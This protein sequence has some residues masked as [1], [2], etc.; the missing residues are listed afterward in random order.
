MTQFEK[1]DTEA[2]YAKFR[3]KRIDLMLSIAGDYS[4]RDYVDAIRTFKR[5]G[6][7]VLLKRDIDEVQVNNYNP[8]WIEA[9]N[10]NLDIQPVL[11]YFGLI[12]YVTDYWSKAD[13]GVT[14]KLKEA[15]IQLKAEPDKQKRAS[16][17]TTKRSVE[18]AH[19][20]LG[21][22]PCY[23]DHHL[24][25]SPDEQCGQCRRREPCTDQE[26]ADRGG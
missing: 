16:R 22:G 8:E 26:K 20:P 11:D 9:W 23:A 4:Y 1:G 19:Q 25:Y 17:T 15:A 14:E 7:T 10:A 24:Q 18:P 13:E 6:S 12:T 3:S 21:S 5:Y 2:D